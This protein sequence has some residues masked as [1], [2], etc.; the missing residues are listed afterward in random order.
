MIDGR[1]ASPFE[2][3]WNTPRDESWFSPFSRNSYCRW[4]FVFSWR[5]LS[6]KKGLPL[7]WA[8]DS[9]PSIIRLLEY[10]AA[11]FSQ[12]FHHFG[13][14]FV[15][16]FWCVTPKRKIISVTINLFNY[17]WN[18]YVNTRVY[19]NTNNFDILL[20]F[21]F[22]SYIKFLYKTIAITHSY[23][24][25]LTRIT[26]HT[27]RDDEN[28]YFPRYIIFA[29]TRSLFFPNPLLVHIDFHT[30]AESVRLF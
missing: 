29:P 15:H 6:S 23:A 11:R 7:V 16:M 18:L 21:M 12:T 22:V 17:T 3:F 4:R 30:W 10:H 24:F 1:V 14:I 9:N 25:F 2:T 20:Y 19:N 27:V 13:V 8:A 5:A 26:E 28:I